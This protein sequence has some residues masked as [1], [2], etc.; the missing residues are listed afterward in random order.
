METVAPIVK[1]LFVE[2]VYGSGV[3]A[4]AAFFLGVG[5]RKVIPKSPN[6]AVLAGLVFVTAIS[7]LPS[8]SRYQFESDSLARIEMD[9][10]VR[11]IYTTKSGALTEPLTWFRTPIGS[12]FMV[13]PNDPIKGGFSEVL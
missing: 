3:V 4:A 9:G 8:L 11:G 5:I 7:T 2:S 10:W 12:T 6:P 1:W 13:M